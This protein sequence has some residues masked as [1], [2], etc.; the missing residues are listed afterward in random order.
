MR[1]WN[2]NRGKAESAKTESGKD[3]NPETL[4]DPHHASRITYRPTTR[5]PPPVTRHIP[6]SYSPPV[7]KIF[8]PCIEFHAH[9]SI[10]PFDLS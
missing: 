1:R 7:K 8:I 9:H 4:R 3:V 2:Q 6:E 10:V 5:H